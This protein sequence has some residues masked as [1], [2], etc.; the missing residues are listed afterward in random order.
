MPKV[1]RLSRLTEL[2]LNPGTTH[3]PHSASWKITCSCPRPSL[4]C[5]WCLQGWFLWVTLQ[6]SEPSVSDALGEKNCLVTYV[7]APREGTSSGCVGARLTCSVSGSSPKLSGFSPACASPSTW[8][9][10]PEPSLGSLLPGASLQALHWGSFCSLK[11]VATSHLFSASACC[12]LGT[13]KMA[14]VF[15]FMFFVRQFLREG[16]ESSLL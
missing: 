9:V 2:N 5:I 13:L 1:T 12:G 10:I 14:F 3:S 16:L 7:M 6:G 15:A 4:C 11:P 8:N